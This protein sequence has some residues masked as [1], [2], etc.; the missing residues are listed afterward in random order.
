MSH[1]YYYLVAS[2]PALPY[3][4]RQAGLPMLHFGAK[5]S[6]ALEDFLQECQKHLSLKDFETIRH[7]VSPSKVSSLSLHPLVRS[8]IQFNHH[9]RNEL[10]WVRALEAD[11]DPAKY[12]HGSREVLPE[13]VDVAARAVKA[14][15]PLEAE[16]VLDSLRWNYLDELERG[17]YF[18]LECLLVYA[19]K[20]KILHRYVEIESPKG[21]EIFGEYQKFEIPA[22]W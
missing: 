3:Y 18:D 19:L 11:R 17:H 9:L 22:V 21:R 4:D 2:L 1:A 14:A 5:P 8:W 20:L 13:L 10:A 7:A 12:I 15:D 16:K 6:F